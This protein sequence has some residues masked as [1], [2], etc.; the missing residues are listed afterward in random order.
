MINKNI[1]NILSKKEIGEIKGLNLKS[2]P[3]ELNPD[4]YY[5]ITEFFEKKYL[6]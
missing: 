4:I 1:K 6:V 3:S 2:R 5:K